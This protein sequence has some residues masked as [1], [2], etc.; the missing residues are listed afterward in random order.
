MSLI[1]GILHYG[2]LVLCMAYIWPTIMR[3]PVPARSVEVSHRNGL[4][5]EVVRGVSEGAE[6]FLHP[7]NQVS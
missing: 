7:G 6:V 2:V 4:K 5:A 1:Q 3:G